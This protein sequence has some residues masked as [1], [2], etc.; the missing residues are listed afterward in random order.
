[1]HV[2]PLSPLRDNAI[3]R[4]VEQT[5]EYLP[6]MYEALCSAENSGEKLMVPGQGAREKRGSA[7]SIF[8]QY[9]SKTW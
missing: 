8:M 5:I 7:H 9:L 3:E 1:M 4:S 6:R 2:P